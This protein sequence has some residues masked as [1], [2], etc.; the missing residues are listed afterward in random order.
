METAHDEALMVSADKLFAQ[1]KWMVRVPVRRAATTIVNSC[2]QAAVNKYTEA[3]QCDTSQAQRVL[4]LRR[5]GRCFSE[6]VSNSSKP[7]FRE[8]GSSDTSLMTAS[9]RSLYCR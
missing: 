9:V 4:C 6:L 3:L 8:I 7:P 2:S 5:R 1:R